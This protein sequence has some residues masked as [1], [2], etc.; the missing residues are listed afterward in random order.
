MAWL[1]IFNSAYEGLG[2]LTLWARWA[3][4]QGPALAGCATGKEGEE[5]NTKEEKER[6]K[7]R[8][9]E[10]R[11]E[12]KNEID[13]RLEICGVPRGYCRDLYFLGPVKLP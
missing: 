5:K 6:K 2:R 3:L 4:A 7:E 9:K 10:K 11:R 13:R 8:K 12:R 1:I